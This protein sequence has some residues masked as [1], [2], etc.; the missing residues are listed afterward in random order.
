MQPFNQVNG[1][2]GMASDDREG[3]DET[4]TIQ[5]GQRHATESGECAGQDM[6]VDVVRWGIRVCVAT[7]IVNN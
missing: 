7:S 1:N 2:R 6:R 4:R 3:G 5:G